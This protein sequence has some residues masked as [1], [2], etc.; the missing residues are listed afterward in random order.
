MSSSEILVNNNYASTV[1]NSPKPFQDYT[2]A[3]AYLEPSNEPARQAFNATISKAVKNLTYYKDVYKHLNIRVK[4]ARERSPCSDEET[5]KT[6]KQAPAKEWFGG[7]VLSLDN[8]PQ[9]PNI[10]WRLGCQ[11]PD[12]NQP[13]DFL[14][15]PRKYRCRDQE[16]KS[17]VCKTE[18][19]RLEHCGSNF[20]EDQDCKTSHC[21]EPACQN[22]GVSP[23]HA[24]LR[25]H[26]ELPHV[27]LKPRHSITITQP[28]AKEIRDPET[29]VLT[30]GELFMI[31]GFTFV[32]RVIKNFYSQAFQ[33]K[34]V[35]YRQSQLGMN[36][37][38]N[39]ALAPISVLNAVRI[40]P[41][42]ASPRAF[43][44][45]TFGSVFSA[46]KENGADVFAI[47][48]FKRVNVEKIKLHM[49]VMKIVGDHVSIY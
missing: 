47:K 7:F 38:F 9:D 22:D 23:H 35:R 42:Y 11:G 20:C 45:G 3:F 48:R 1:E 21:K 32:F 44:Q 46:W 30:N 41:Y 15:R 17:Q 33:N 29:H 26:R 27:L 2:G 39:R 24:I 19:C 28:M 5:H 31:G 4:D 12:G 43:A 16:C 25:L 6:A 36:Y 49:Q 18:H 37:H 34:F 8:L 14:L 10:G 40:G 13:S